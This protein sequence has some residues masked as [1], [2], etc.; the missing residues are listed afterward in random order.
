[1]NI[2]YLCMFLCPQLLYANESNDGDRNV[3]PVYDILLFM[4]SRIAAMIQVGGYL[5]QWLTWSQVIQIP[6]PPPAPQAIAKK[7][8]LEA[9]RQLRNPRGP[10]N[11]GKKPTMRAYLI[12]LRVSWV[13]NTPKHTVVPKSAEIFSYYGRRLRALGV[14]EPQNPLRPSKSISMGNLQPQIRLQTLRGKPLA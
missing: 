4:D 5:T 14:K 3:R 2:L 9:P 8:A 1:M 12:G 13:C 6:P 10:H 7:K 11:K